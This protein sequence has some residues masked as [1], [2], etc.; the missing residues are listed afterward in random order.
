MFNPKS[1]KGAAIL[2]FGCRRVDISYSIFKYLKS[3][4]GAALHLTDIPTNKKDTDGVSK[5]R[6]SNTFFE[7][8]TGNVGGVLYLDHP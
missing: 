6:I 3:Q 7:Y 4:Q 8:I 1:E 5:Y 2:C